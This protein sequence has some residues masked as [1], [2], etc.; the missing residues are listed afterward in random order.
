MKPAVRL[1]RAGHE[2]QHL[3]PR[4]QDRAA[5]KGQAG[6]GIGGHAGG[7]DAVMDDGDLAAQLGRKAVGLITGG[8]D[9]RI[10]LHHRLDQMR[11][12]RDRHEAHLVPVGADLGVE[13]HIL[14]AGAV[15]QLGIDQQARVGPDLLQEQRLSPAR[16]AD[17]DVGVKPV[18]VAQRTCAP[19]RQQAAFR[20]VRIGP[21]QGAVGLHR[22]R[23]LV[24]QG[25]DRAGPLVVL[26]RQG[27]DLVAARG[28]GRGQMRKLARKVL[29]DEQDL[30]SWIGKAARSKA[31]V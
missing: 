11:R 12:P 18:P 21:A 27:Q 8:R 5:R 19:R 22:R 31:R 14:A 6:R 28:Q 26:I 16:M 13:A 29:V 4:A 10:G 7:V 17:D 25:P 15:H 9:G 24:A 23:R 20:M 2:G 1:Q 3:V 30:H